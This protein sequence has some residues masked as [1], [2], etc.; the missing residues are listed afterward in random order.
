ME[1]KHLSSSLKA[2]MT[3]VSKLSVQFIDLLSWKTIIFFNCILQVFGEHPYS[4]H[5][6]GIIIDHRLPYSHR[7][8]ALGLEILL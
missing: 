7:I 5:P 8:I 2:F 4:E 6:C 3:K 1:G